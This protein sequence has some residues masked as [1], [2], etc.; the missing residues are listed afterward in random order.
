MAFVFA[1]Q[2]VYNAPR[3]YNEPGSSNWL[4]VGA[5]LTG[6]MPLVLTAYATAPFVNSIYLRVPGYAT[7]SSDLMSRFTKTMPADTPIELVT[8][9]LAGTQKVSSLRIKDLRPR[10]RMNLPSL[11]R[12]FGWLRVANL[13][14]KK[15]ADTNRLLSEGWWWRWVTEPRNKFYVNIGDKEMRR[16]KAPGVLKDVMVAINKYS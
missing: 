1:L 6:A 16:S 15:P 14:L 12:P 2:C 3:I 13:E 5:I 10:D 8:V 9:R 7:R 4:V 11:L